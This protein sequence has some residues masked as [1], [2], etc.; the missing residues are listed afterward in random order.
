MQPILPITSGDVSPG[1]RSLLAH[2]S[3]RL[4]RRA[5][6]SVASLQLTLCLRLLPP[7]FFPPLLVHQNS[8]ASLFPPLFS[9]RFF[10]DWLQYGTGEEYFHPFPFFFP[11]SLYKRDT[12]ASVLSCPPKSG[13]IPFSH[14]GARRTQIVSDNN[15]PYYL[16]S[17]AQRSF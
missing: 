13:L 15:S 10:I 1:I 11:S 8:P 4:L 3:L 6:K 14:A 9:A 5:V 7:L 12:T 2:W 16:A 17:G